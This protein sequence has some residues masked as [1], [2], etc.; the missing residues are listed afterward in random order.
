MILLNNKTDI[1]KAFPKEKLDYKDIKA[2]IEESN[3]Y[4]GQR[5][6]EG[7]DFEMPHNLGILCIGKF[8][9]QRVFDYIHFCKTGEFKK[10]SNVKTFNYIYKIMWFRGLTNK[11]KATLNNNLYKYHASRYKIRRPLAKLLKE[12]HDFYK[13]E[14][15]INK[16]YYRNGTNIKV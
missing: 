13:N 7:N 4:I 15:Y 16:F 8:K 3:L 11:K 2:I 10:Q 6:L 12:G 14:E 5:L 1:Q 9:N